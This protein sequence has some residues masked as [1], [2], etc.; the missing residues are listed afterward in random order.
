MEANPWPACVVEAGEGE[1]EEKKEKKKALKNT[2]IRRIGGV[3]W[4]SSCFRDGEALTAV[5]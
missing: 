1:L 2:R 3:P 4:R 5:G